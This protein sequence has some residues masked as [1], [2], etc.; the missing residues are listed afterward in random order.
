VATRADAETKAAAS[1]RGSGEAWASRGLMQLPSFFNPSTMKT[2]RRADRRG[3]ARRSS[4]FKKGDTNFSCVQK[5]RRLL[6]W[7]GSG[8]IRDLSAVII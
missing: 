3:G 4:S 5:G 8:L 6:Y 2:A 7:L 1:L